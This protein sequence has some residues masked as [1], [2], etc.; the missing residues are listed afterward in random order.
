MVA[1]TYLALR[2]IGLVY[3]RVKIQFVRPLHRHFIK[4]V[5]MSAEIDLVEVASVL[6]HDTIVDLWKPP[7]E[8]NGIFKTYF[9]DIA[10]LAF[11]LVSPK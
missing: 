9:L 5:D 11:L 7:S 8:A 1:H 2:L 3:I 10:L 4:C 6:G